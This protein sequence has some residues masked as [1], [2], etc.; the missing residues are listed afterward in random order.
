MIKRLSITFTLGGVILAMLWIGAYLSREPELGRLESFSQV[1]R[2]EDGSI[3]NLRL[4][5]SGHWREKASL[6][7]ADTKLVEMLVAYEDKDLCP[8][9]ESIQL[10]CQGYIQFNYV[11]TCCFRCVNTDYANSSFNALEL[12][13]RSF[14][15]KLMQMLE[16]VRLERHFPKMKS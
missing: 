6:E 5:P 2:S 10:L 9:V 14:K 12:Q 15:T 3:I 1:I 11:R 7:N 16:A 4:T 13:T 8:I